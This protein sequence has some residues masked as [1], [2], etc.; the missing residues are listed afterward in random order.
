MVE[1]VQLREGF[2]SSLF[3]SLARILTVVTYAYQ[4]WAISAENKFITKTWRSKK[5]WSHFGI[6]N[7]SGRSR[8][9]SNV[10]WNRRW[11]WCTYLT[12][13]AMPKHSMKKMKNL[14][15]QKYEKDMIAMMMETFVLLRK[16]DT[17]N[18]RCIKCEQRNHW[19]VLTSRFGHMD[20]VHKKEHLKATSGRLVCYGSLRHGSQ[21]FMLSS[22]SGVFTNKIARQ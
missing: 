18:F 4:H 19:T 7:V 12:R 10:I 9:L 16:D 2:R 17:R 21:E 1:Q 20:W 6:Q 8:M 22:G 11:R 5:W 3:L 15:S 14:N 13:M